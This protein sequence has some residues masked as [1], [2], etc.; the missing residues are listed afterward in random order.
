MRQ[1]VYTTARFGLFMNFSD[2]LK[3]KRGRNLTL[4]EKGLCSLAAG[5][6]GSLIGTPADLILVRMQADSMA[7]PEKRRGYTGVFNAAKRIPAEEGF[8][9]LWKGGTPTVVRA[10]AYN[11]GMFS[12]Y[13][14]SKERLT[15]VLPGY[16]NTIMV[17]SSIIA[18]TSAATLSLPF[19]NAKTK[20]QNMSPNADGTMPFKNIF[21]CM[22]K[23][24][25]S[26]GVLGLWVGLPVYIV[27]VCPHVII[28]FLVSEQLK[29]VFL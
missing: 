8:L 15:K 14:E 27:R 23:T 9:S 22:V 20:I 17:I 25:K 18:G 12:T 28:T 5:G 13:D 1:A 19:D 16:K 11:L 24:A 2:S 26:N 7:P 3:A 21:D 10:M 29:K 4:V 6:I